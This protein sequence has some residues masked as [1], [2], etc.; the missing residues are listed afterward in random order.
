[1]L[2]D[3]SQILS[4]LHFS[5]PPFP[6]L[7]VLSCIQPSFNKDE[8]ALSGNLRSLKCISS[9]LHLVSLLLH[10]L[11]S[12]SLLSAILFNLPRYHLNIHRTIQINLSLL[13]LTTLTSSFSFCP[14]R[15]TNGQCLKDSIHNMF[16]PPINYVSKS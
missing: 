7:N 6:L 4:F 15:R 5:S 2:W 10:F 14:T 1:V 13:L 9:R 3:P 12:L 11:F 16:Y 8:R